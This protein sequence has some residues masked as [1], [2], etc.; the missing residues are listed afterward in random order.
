MTQ[1]GP[2]DPECIKY[3]NGDDNLVDAMLHYIQI[4]FRHCMA[5]TILDFDRLT[6]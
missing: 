1:N 2:M 5:S 3:V 4:L 6:R